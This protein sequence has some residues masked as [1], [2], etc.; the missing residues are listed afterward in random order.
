MNDLRTLLFCFCIASFHA[1]VTFAQSDA[2][3]DEKQK[4]LYETC[5]AVLANPTADTQEYVATCET[6]VEKYEE[7]LATQDRVVEQEETNRALL[8]QRDEISKSSHDIALENLLTLAAPGTR[9]D[10]K[11]DCKLF[12]VEPEGRV[13]VIRAGQ[14]D[15]TRSRTVGLSHI[16]LVTEAPGGLQQVIDQALNTNELASIEYSLNTE[17]L[18]KQD[19]STADDLLNSLMTGLGS[20]KSYCNSQ[21]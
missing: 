14:L 7:L 17:W 1:E 20:M 3:L 13:L 16:D 6:F 18:S 9:W 11:T 5:Q 21:N 19:Q 12:L 2:G 4:K 15:L 8:E 10:S